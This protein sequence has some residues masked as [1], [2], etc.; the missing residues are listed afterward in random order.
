MDLEVTW[1]T[2]FADMIHVVQACTNC[3]SATPSNQHIVNHTPCT[4]Y[5]PQCVTSEAVCDE[6]KLLGHTSHKLQL[7]RCNQC[8]QYNINCCKFVVLFMTSDSEEK[9]QRLWN[10][11]R[12]NLKVVKPHLNFSYYLPFWM[13]C[14]LARL[15]SVHGPIGS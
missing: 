10:V 7:R 2:Q 15:L 4:S 9:N 13:Q 8:V 1:Y 5:C 3:L 12:Q 11:S 6:C 14:T